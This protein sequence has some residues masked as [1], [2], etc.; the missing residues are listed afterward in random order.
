[1]TAS[2]LI[3]RYHARDPRALARALTLVENDAA[4][5]ADVL[6]AARA[7]PHRPPVVGVTGSPG[8]GKSTLVSALIAHLRAAGDTVAVLAVDPSSPFSGG[9]ILGDRIRMLR[10]HADPGVYVR[11]IASRGALGGLSART[12][13]ALSVLEGFAFDWIFIETVGVGQSEVDI[14]AVAD[15]T[16]LVLTPG[17]GDGVQAFK[18]G[19]M[20]IA[21]VMVVNKSDL[22]GAD[23]VVRELRAAQGLVTSHG[24]DDWF[25]PV[26][27]ARADQQEG[28]EGVLNAIRA[29]RA[30]LGEAGLHARRHERARFE[31]RA[32]L[33]DRAGRLVAGAGAD[34]IDRLAR[35]DLSADQAAAELLQ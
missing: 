13:Q 2:T 7:A 26:V 25:A 14:A 8:S 6:R 24:P 32:A 30:H 21:D 15:H 35:G 1:M 11:S 27:K 34:L 17:G 18:A 3:D 9:A 4:G 31:L 33:Q 19:I 23:R 29:H 16:V 12:L 28:I 22:P 5:S 10:H 20:E